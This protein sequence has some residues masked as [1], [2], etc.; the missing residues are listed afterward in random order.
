MTCERNE[1]IQ[2][3]IKGSRTEFWLDVRQDGQVFPLTG[4]TVFE[5]VFCVPGGDDVVIALTAPTSPESGS[6][7][8]QLTAAQTALLSE[9]VTDAYLKLDQ[10]PSD[11]ILVSYENLFLVKE[12]C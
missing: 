7:F 8:V 10:V 3:I 6:I 1:E 4:F 12:I 5:L 11:P 2:E 9:S